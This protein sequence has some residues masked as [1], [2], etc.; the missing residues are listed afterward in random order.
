M[1]ACLSELIQIGC[2]PRTVVAL[3]CSAGGD[4]AGTSLHICKNSLDR[5]WPPTTKD[6]SLQECLMAKQDPAALNCHQVGGPLVLCWWLL[7]AV[8]LIV[9]WQCPVV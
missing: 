8:H 2:S 3:S 9:K 7:P 5:K 1:G 4:A 6:E